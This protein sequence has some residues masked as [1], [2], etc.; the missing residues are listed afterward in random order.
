[1][2]TWSLQWKGK[3]MGETRG[4]RSGDERREET[5][6]ESRGGQREG[7][8]DERSPPPQPPS[9]G[10]SSVS[11]H[12]NTPVCHPP[13]PPAVSSPSWSDPCLHR[14]VATRYIYNIYFKISRDYHLAQLPTSHQSG[15]LPYAEPITCLTPCLLSI[16]FLISCPDKRSL[17]NDRPIA[18]T[19][20]SVADLP[21]CPVISSQPSPILPSPSL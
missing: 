18:Q 9:H 19:S 20:S 15:S 21:T 11:S 5:T 2:P 8:R 1:M 6:R 14:T 13:H 3:T 4:E 7:R 12:A 10:K 16:T 17:A